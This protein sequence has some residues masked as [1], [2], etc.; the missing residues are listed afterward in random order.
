MSEVD[1]IFQQVGVVLKDA[2]PNRYHL[3]G[4]RAYMGELMKSEK[5][6]A[7]NIAKASMLRRALK[8]KSLA[9]RPK[10]ENTNANK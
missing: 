4:V 5:F 9:L 2:K 10:K 3:E 1:K 7:A 8:R 6:G